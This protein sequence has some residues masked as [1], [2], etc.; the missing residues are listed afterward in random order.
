MSGGGLS[1]WPPL[2]GGGGSGNDLAKLTEMLSDTV[3]LVGEAA[4]GSTESESA[5]RIRRITQT[6]TV[7]LGDDITIDWAGTSTAFDKKWA[8]RLTYSYG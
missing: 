5:W 4:V 1:R 3:L 8:D 6:P 7:Q 2:N